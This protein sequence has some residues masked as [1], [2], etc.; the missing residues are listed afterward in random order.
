MR[1]SPNPSPPEWIPRMSRKAILLALGLMVLAGTV[2][3]SVVAVVRH[4]PDEYLRSAVPPGEERK[5]ESGAFQSEML[6]MLAR[7]NGEQDF[8]ANFTDL[9]VNSYLDEDFISSGL[10]ER[11]LP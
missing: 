8:E 10:A 4:E 6:S 3:A 11:T 7:I 9:R 2:G 5:K 1:A